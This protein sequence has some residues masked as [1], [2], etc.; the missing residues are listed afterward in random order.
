MQSI[1]QNL[2]SISD[3]DIEYVSGDSADVQDF[4][5]DF[6]VIDTKDSPIIN[7]NP[8]YF[9]I[10]ENGVNENFEVA[11]PSGAPT[12][13]NYECKAA[14]SQMIIKKKISGP[15]DLSVY[16]NKPFVKMP[17]TPNSSTWHGLYSITWAGDRFVAVGYASHFAYSVGTTG[18]NWVASNYFKGVNQN[19]T[20]SYVTYLNGKLIVAGSDSNTLHLFHASDADGFSTWTD[21]G[22]NLS[23]ISGWGASP[24]IRKIIF[25]GSKYVILGR[26]NRIAT[27]VDLI[28]FT[29]NSGLSNFIVTTGVAQ[30]ERELTVNLSW[31]GSKYFVVSNTGW[32]GSTRKRLISSPDLTTW[33]LVS[34]GIEST[35]QENEGTHYLAYGGGSTLYINSDGTRPSDL[36]CAVTVNG[37]DWTIGSYPSQFLG[38]TQDITHDGTQFIAIKNDKI[39]TSSDGLS[40]KVY[41]KISATLANGGLKIAANGEACL[42]TW[43]VSDIWKAETV[44]P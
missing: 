15:V 2:R 16:Y 37:T 19:M 17:Y 10:L 28:T 44:Y 21:V 40:W 13:W 29:N 3:P 4:N 26:G 25:D 6:L 35:R 39:A 42:V 31:D 33:T 43:N 1:K 22:F 36:M 7:L 24:Q 32:S 30:A 18:D 12:Q 23:S 11:D 27:S 38:H 14:G 34:T 20:F 9:T 41:N 8:L 5:K